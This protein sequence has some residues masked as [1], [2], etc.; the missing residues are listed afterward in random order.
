MDDPYWLVDN[1]TLAVSLNEQAAFVPQ[2]VAAALAAGAERIAV[3]KLK[4]TTG[5]RQANP[6]P[7]GL[8]RWD[9]SRRPAFNTYRVAIE[10]LAGV[11]AAERERWDAVGQVRLEQKEGTTTVLF[12]R[13][14]ES[15]QARVKAIAPTAELVD[16]WGRGET[17]EARGGYFVIDLPGALCSQTIADYCMIGGTTYYLVQ[18]AEESQ[19]Q[20]VDE[21]LPGHVAP[22]FSDASPTPMPSPVVTP[23]P[24]AGSKPT[25]APSPAP[26]PSPTM[27][28]SPTVTPSPTPSAA[29]TRATASPVTML[30]ANEVEVDIQG[31]ESASPPTYSGLV[32]LGLGLALG[33]GLVVWVLARR[34][35]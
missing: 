27:T 17:I 19:G 4:D 29:P 13:L 31:G 28:S 7:F 8:V 5:D 34:G 22:Q 18:Q 30:E 6:E 24:T 14:P 35:G 33:A 21:Q 2:A 1:W 32:V 23:S 12:A 20:A 3:Y 26:M 9:D 15:Q 16:M 25:V 10:L 11:T